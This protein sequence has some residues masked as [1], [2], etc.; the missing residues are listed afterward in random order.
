M[1]FARALL[2]ELEGFRGAVYDDATGQPIVPGVLCQGHPTAGYGRAL[3]VRPLSRDEADYLFD[4]DYI[5]AW[6]TC[7]RVV[8][9]FGALPQY[10][11]AVLIAMAYQL[12]EAGLKKFRRMLDAIH[13]ED[14]LEAEA[15]MLDSLAARQTP[16]RYARLVKVWRGEELIA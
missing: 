6:H 3:D 4:N 13:D 12:G 11:Q 8:P 1:K 5:A 15:Q 9:T 16:A 2:H 10:R 14:W 7:D